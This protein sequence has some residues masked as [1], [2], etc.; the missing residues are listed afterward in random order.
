MNISMK[1]ELT[2]NELWDQAM[3]D[4]EEDED[5]SGDLMVRTAQEN[6]TVLLR[7]FHV[8]CLFS[9]PLSDDDHFITVVKWM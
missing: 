8:S 9:S 7:A 2:I 5:L 3:Q 4:S 1:I 6:T